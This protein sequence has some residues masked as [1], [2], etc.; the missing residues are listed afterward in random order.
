MQDQTSDAPSPPKYDLFSK[1]FF[2]D[3]HPAF[4]RMRVED[5]LYLHPHLKVWIST[6]YDDI[7]NLMRDKRF[8]AERVEQ[9]GIGASEAMKEK[10]EACNRF[11]S[12]WMVLRDPPRH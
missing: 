1:D 2:D 11:L 3:P 12:H 8:S 7:Q 6:R 10:L 4:R 9:F 5:P